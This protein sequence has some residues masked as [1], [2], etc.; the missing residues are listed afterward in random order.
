MSGVNR[1]P[2]IAGNWKMHTTYDEAVSLAE[3]YRERLAQLEGVEC[4]LIPPYPWIVPLAEKLEGS[5][6]V[7]GAQNCA[8]IDQGALTG[9]VSARM[10]APFCRYVIVGHSERR[11]QL[12]ESDEM[13]AAKL[14]AAVRNGL[15]PILCVGELLAERDQGLAERVVERQ[16]GSALEALEAAHLTRLV[17]A[18]EPVWAIGTGRPATPSDAQAIAACIREWIAQ[19]FGSDLAATVRI[20]YGGSVNA[21]NAADFLQLP[22]IDG[23]LVGGASLDVEQ[24]CEIVRVA[25]ELARATNW[26]TAQN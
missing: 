18:Y 9:E 21:G 16:L 13:V 26:S 11:H 5:T 19:R 10:L 24:F 1:V 20:Q 14:Q 3:A 12:G 23:A 4:A 2:L 15:S 25:R 8:T 22:D 7:L 6:L 17:I